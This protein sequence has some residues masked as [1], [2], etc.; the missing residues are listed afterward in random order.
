MSKRKKIEKSLLTLFK[1]PSEFYRIV[2]GPKV[3]TK[4]LFQ[5]FLGLLDYLYNSCCL[6]SSVYNA[7]KTIQYGVGVVS[8][9]VDKWLELEPQITVLRWEIHQQEGLQHQGLSG[10]WN[11]AVILHKGGGANEK[12]LFSVKEPPG[13]GDSSRR[14]LF[15]INGI[16]IS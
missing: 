9:P 12:H 15:W 8:L 13:G 11:K 4:S 5:V 14:L 10:Y 3:S 7:I 6:C 2:L 16:P 1:V